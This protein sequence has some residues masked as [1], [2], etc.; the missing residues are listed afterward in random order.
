MEAGEGDEELYARTEH[1]DGTTTGSQPQLQPQPQRTAKRARLEGGHNNWKQTFL[2]SP[3]AAP[4]LTTQTSHHRNIHQP[5]TTLAHRVKQQQQAQQQQ[6]QQECVVISGC[7]VRF[8]FPPYPTQIAMMERVLRALRQQQHALL[9]SPTGTGK[10]L[11]LLCA[12]LAWQ[13]Q[14]KARLL[15]QHDNL[16]QH[17]PLVQ[18]QLQSRKRK[19]KSGRPQQPHTCR[20]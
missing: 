10:S 20:R 9:E 6:A 1:D 17:K 12:T 2:S 5:A 19:R 11:S 7:T 18:F 8:P 3:V 15:A 14:E 4:H 16:P 13:K